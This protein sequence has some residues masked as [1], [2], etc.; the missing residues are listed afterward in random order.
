MAN[1]ESLLPKIPGVSS[2]AQCLVSGFLSSCVLASQKRSVFLKD[3]WWV[4]HLFQR[5][6]L[7]RIMPGWIKIGNSKILPG[8]Q[9]QPQVKASSLQV[10]SHLGNL[11]NNW[12][13]VPR[14]WE[15]ALPWSELGGE[16]RITCSETC[17]KFTLSFS[18][19]Y[20]RGKNPFPSF[21]A[22]ALTWKRLTL[23]AMIGLKKI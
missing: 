5:K 20:S 3:L 23:T 19:I 6:L 2:R 15:L 1:A 22:L 21:N 17:S 13:N 12:P 8:P 9:L 11:T 7:H 4:T 10:W 14:M 16:I 18:K